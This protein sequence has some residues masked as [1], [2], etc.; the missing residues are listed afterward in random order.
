MTDS[1]LVCVRLPTHRS[2]PWQPSV[3]SV[4]VSMAV[5]FALTPGVD[6]AWPFIPWGN[7]TIWR[8]LQINKMAKILIC[9]YSLCILMPYYQT[10]G[11]LLGLGPLCF[12]RCFQITVHS[13]MKKKKKKILLLW[14]WYPLAKITVI[15]FSFLFLITL[16]HWF[17]FSL[18]LVILAT[19][20]IT[21]VSR[22][23]IPESF[24]HF[25]LY[26]HH[27]FYLFHFISNTH[28]VS[29]YYSVLSHPCFSIT[30]NTNTNSVATTLESPSLLQV[31]YKLRIC[32]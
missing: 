25:V 1:S 23:R 32:M 5:L 27:Q 9:I 14:G 28:F 24:G 30:A 12:P 4:T 13:L 7:C 22:W 31:F 26:P 18:P 29:Q 15:I 2:G 19:S 10:Q 16:I 8:I 6:P 20:Q 11:Q 17:I 21:L 3:C